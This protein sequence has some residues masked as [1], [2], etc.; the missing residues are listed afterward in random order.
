MTLP[1][2]KAVSKTYDQFLSELPVNLKHHLLPEQ[3][4][5]FLEKMIARVMPSQAGGRH[6]Y[7]FRLDDPDAATSQVGFQQNDYFLSDANST[8]SGSYQHQAW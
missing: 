5:A 3:V 4:Y 8:L 7:L 1:A 2:G 6:V